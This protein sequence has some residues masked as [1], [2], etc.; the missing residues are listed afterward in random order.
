MIQARNNLL[1]QLLLKYGAMSSEHQNL[2]RVLEKDT[3]NGGTEIFQKLSERLTASEK[4]QLESFSN[5]IKHIYEYIDIQES[6]PRSRDYTA[7]HVV[8]VA[9]NISDLELAVATY[10]RYMQ[11]RDAQGQ[12]WSNAKFKTPDDYYKQMSRLYDV[13]DRLNGVNVFQMDA[14]FL[15]GLCKTHFW[16]G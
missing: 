3:E 12:T 10:I 8:D 4:N 5:E 15:F 6:I 1:K 16:L 13:A 14:N 11:S 7:K 9:K 2:I